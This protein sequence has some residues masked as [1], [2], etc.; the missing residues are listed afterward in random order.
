MPLKFDQYAQ[1]GNALLNDLAEELGNPDDRKKAGR[2][3]KAVL[4]SFR[5]IITVE[6]NIQLLSQLP[7]MLKGIYVLNWHSVHSSPAKIK[8]LSDFVQLVKEYDFPTGDYDFG[9]ETETLT[10]IKVVIKI[11]KRYISKGEVEDIQSVLPDPL[12]RLWEEEVVD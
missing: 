12:A 8:T 1:Q 6:E 10:D 9:N 7:F 3:L 11:L 4:H 2:I 5:D